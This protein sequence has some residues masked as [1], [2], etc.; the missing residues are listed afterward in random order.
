MSNRRFAV[1]SF[2]LGRCG[3]GG[4]FIYS[5]IEA[6]K[7]KYATARFV[8]QKVKVPLSDPKVRRG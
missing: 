6:T 2:C 1:N 7:L 3:R 5:Q 8:S 4:G